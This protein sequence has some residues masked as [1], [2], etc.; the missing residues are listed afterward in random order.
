M[1]ATDIFLVIAFITL[2]SCAQTNGSKNAD[3]TTTLTTGPINID[4]SQPGKYLI[5]SWVNVNLINGLKNLNQLSSR[6]EIAQ[7]IMPY[8]SLSFDTTPGGKLIPY[9][10]V[11]YEMI[12]E[13]T[14]A[15]IALKPFAGTVFKIVY[16][17]TGDDGIQYYNAAD[18][19]IEIRDMTHADK[20]LAKYKKAPEHPSGT[21]EPIYYLMNRMLMQ[22]LYRVEDGNGATL[23]DKVQFGKLDISGFGNFTTYQFLDL[24]L[25]SDSKG[26]I[27]PIISLRNSSN[28]S[29]QFGYRRENNRTCLYDYQKENNNWV[30]K[31]GKVRYI[32]KPI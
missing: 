3:S 20:V 24:D 8:R 15:N 28:E 6:S 32:L 2:L 4:T 26:K 29:E 10:E 1:K 5:G 7:W 13:D 11:D 25:Y 12:F 22:G 18:S 17:G 9:V 30:L 21:K 31:L 16:S 23:F 27:Y 19:S 14:M